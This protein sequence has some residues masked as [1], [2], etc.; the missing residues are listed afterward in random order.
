M[1]CSWRDKVGLYVDGELDAAGQEQFSSH[2]R[3]CTDC[4]S[5]VNAE[6]EL[7]KRL[8]IA[9]NAFQAPPELHASVY[10]LVR[11]QRSASPWWKWA[12]APLCM[13]LLGVIVYQWFPKSRPDPMMARVVDQHITNLASA[14]PVDVVSEDR[15]TVK[16]WFQ[17]KLPFTFNLPEVAGSNFKLDGGKMAYAEQRPGAEL[18]FETG[19][20][21]ISVFIFQARDGQDNNG[22]S[23]EL[24][25][26]VTRWRQGG[27][28]YYLVTDASQYEAGRLV[29][30]FKAANK[31]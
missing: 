6:M 30:M 13:L 17:G 3:D 24:S 29:E 21:K 9:G 18:W 11:P 25:F 5:A 4:T 7:K 31:S 8:R 12:M 23:H 10:R 1:N 20:H 16:P 28:D 26:N 22:T 14:N 27:L 19:A 15:H 2:L